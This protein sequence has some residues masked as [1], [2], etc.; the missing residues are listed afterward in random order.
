[1]ATP[2]N[3]G[4]PINDN[5]D[6]TAIHIN[7]NGATGYLSSADSSDQL[8]IYSLTVPRSLR[9]IPV[10]YIKGT[11]YDSASKAPLS[12]SVAVTNT[13]NRERVYRSD[14]DYSDGQFI[15]TLPVGANYAVHIQKE[16]YMFDS[17]QYDI[18][19]SELPDEVF[20]NEIF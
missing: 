18:S 7:M 5:Y 14:S 20:E 16:G 3:L 4:S 6:Q 12:A 19:Q 2:T 9:P 15:A 10:V 1:W 8:D 13:H 11:V 17:R